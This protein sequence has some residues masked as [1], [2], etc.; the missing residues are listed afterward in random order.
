MPKPFS[1]IGI[2]YTAAGAAI[3]AFGIWRAVDQIQALPPDAPAAVGVITL[4][5]GGIVALGLGIVATGAFLNYA[6]RA[7]HDLA[8]LADASEWRP[9]KERKEPE[10]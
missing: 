4:A 3:C 10:M 2:T 1:I 5:G 6:A 7:V 9:P 8:R